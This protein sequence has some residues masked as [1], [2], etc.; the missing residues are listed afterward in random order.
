MDGTV[1]DP[2]G[3]LNGCTVDWFKMVYCKWQ[4]GPR[5]SLFL[6][7]SSSFES[8]NDYL[9][10]QNFQDCPFNRT[11][12][13]SDMTMSIYVDCASLGV[14]T[15]RIDDEV[16][17]KTGQKLHLSFDRKRLHFFEKDGKALRH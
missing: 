16:S 10:S 8:I 11:F 14:I 3:P 15:V 2:Y 12:G 7:Y 6:N 5:P 1:F 17:Y 4:Y 13:P 9:N